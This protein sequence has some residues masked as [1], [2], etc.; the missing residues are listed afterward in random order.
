M[1][2]KTWAS[3]GVLA[4]ITLSLAGLSYNLLSTPEAQAD[5]KSVV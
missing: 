3:F 4:L 1:T 2:H 5:R